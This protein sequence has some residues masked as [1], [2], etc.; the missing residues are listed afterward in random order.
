MTRTTIYFGSN[1]ALDS[2]FSRALGDG[3][4]DKIKHLVAV[5]ICK[6]HRARIKNKD[7]PDEVAAIALA[8][9]NGYAVE[10]ESVQDLPGFANL[11]AS[12]RRL[13]EQGRQLEEQSLIARGEYNHGLQKFSEAMVMIEKAISDTATAQ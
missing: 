13:E 6:L 5:A 3:D 11:E 10:E 8:V 2:V 1:S 4:H 12:I 7:D 9:L